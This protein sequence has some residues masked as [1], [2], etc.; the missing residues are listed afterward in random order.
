[1]SK[2]NIDYAMHSQP[3]QNIEIYFC[4]GMTE[5][6]RSLVSAFTMSIAFSMNVLILLK[7]ITKCV[8]E[9]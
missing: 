6:S 1:M 2:L 8:V 7:C 5:N 9:I 3:A 4:H